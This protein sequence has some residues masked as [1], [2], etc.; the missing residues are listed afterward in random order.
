MLSKNNGQVVQNVSQ[1]KMALEFMSEAERNLLH[2]AA[3]TSGLL[4]REK[5]HSTANVLSCGYNDLPEYNSPSLLAQLRPMVRSE[6]AKEPLVSLTTTTTTASDRCAHTPSTLPQLDTCTPHRTTRLGYHSSMATPS[7]Y[8]YE[9][10][11]FG[12]IADTVRCTRRA[13]ERIHK[14]TAALHRTTGFGDSLDTC[15]IM[16]A[17]RGRYTAADYA[18]FP[19]YPQHIRVAPQLSQVIKEDIRTRVGKPRYHEIT[20]QDLARFDSQCLQLGRFHT[21]LL[22]FD[23]LNSLDNQV[24]ELR[25]VSDIT[26]LEG[27]NGKIKRYSVLQNA[28]D[29]VY[30]KTPV[31]PTSGR[32]SSTFTYTSDSDPE[33][34]FTER[35]E[36]A[37]AMLTELPVLTIVQY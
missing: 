3:F 24:F 10:N 37:G 31:T 20:I 1:R 14:T 19:R 15:G 33:M 28:G 13:K 25:S 34:Q 4:C 30:A 5:S 27:N 2:G 22:V 7:A 18:R 16:S 35:S 29:I 12:D 11:V 17:E 9:K 6:S 21:N 32:A 26:E 23:W 8:M 36:Y